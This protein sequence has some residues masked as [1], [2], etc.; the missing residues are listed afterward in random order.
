MGTG[1]R[2]MDF[3]GKVA[4]VTGGGRGL[5]HAYA[6]TL[7][8]HGASV[9]LAEVDTELGQKSEAT[10]KTINPEILFVQTDVGEVA[11]VEACKAAVLER[12]GRVDILINNAAEQ[13]PQESIENISR[14]QLER[15]FQTNIFSMFF[16]V[17]F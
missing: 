7:A 11:S 17:T 10:L 6:E 2:V 12:F 9:C 14:E 1:S 4:V 16:M 5:G 15:T 8:R 13:H 3:T